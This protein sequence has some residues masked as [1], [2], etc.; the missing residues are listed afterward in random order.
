MR[1]WGCVAFLLYKLPDS[2][3]ATGKLACRD[4]QT[5]DGATGMS[6]Q[7]YAPECECLSGL[8]ECDA[9][10]NP[11]LILFGGAADRRHEGLCHRLIAR[12]V[13]ARIII[14]R[15][16]VTRIIIT[17]VVVTRIIVAGIIIAGVV[18]A[19]IIVVGVIIVG[20]IGA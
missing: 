12:V 15:V 8:R 18:I 11:Q 10:S 6:T 2:G 19:R 5:L 14:A 4:A 3:W 20:T 13:V 17:R 16:V 1:R 9:R 7:A